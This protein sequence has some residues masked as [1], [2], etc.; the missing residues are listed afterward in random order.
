MRAC[1]FQLSSLTN[2]Y[3]PPFSAR[4]PAQFRPFH[5]RA[6]HLHLL[7]VCCCASTSAPSRFSSSARALHTAP[8]TLFPHTRTAS[9]T[10]TTTTFHSPALCDA[11]TLYLQRATPNPPRD[12]PGVPCWRACRACGRMMCLVWVL[13]LLS[14]CLS[15]L[16][17]WGGCRLSCACPLIITRVGLL[18][19]KRRL[20]RNKQLRTPHA[21]N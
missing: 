4:P 10:T 17:Y 5:L 9:A 2:T 21:T 14:W 12:R 7:S 8:R 15:W 20:L 19:A 6:P 1:F 18:A 11:L 3:P 16:V 13:V